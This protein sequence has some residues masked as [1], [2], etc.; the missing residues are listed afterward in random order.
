MDY[1][2]LTARNQFGGLSYYC[3]Q[4]IT[5]NLYAATNSDKTAFLCSGQLTVL[6]TKDVLCI[7]ASTPCGTIEVK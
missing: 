6:D 4:N 3:A 1:F 2:I 5:R 7:T